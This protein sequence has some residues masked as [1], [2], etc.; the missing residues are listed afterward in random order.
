MKCKTCK[1]SI[2]YNEIVGSF[3]GCNHPK[4]HYSYSVDTKAL[5][6]DEVLVEIDEGWGMACGPDFG[7]VHYEEKE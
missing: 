6:S 2:P 4:F 1:H 3:L 7:C 5:D